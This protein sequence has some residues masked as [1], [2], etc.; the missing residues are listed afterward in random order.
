[1]KMNQLTIHEAN[2]LDKLQ[3]EY[4]LTSSQVARMAYK[5]FNK[6]ISRQCAWQRLNGITASRAASDV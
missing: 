5:L 4:N 3:V 1:M 2:E 6:Q